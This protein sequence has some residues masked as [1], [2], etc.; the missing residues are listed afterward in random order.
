MPNTFK[1]KLAIFSARYGSQFLSAAAAAFLII[2]ANA[3]LKFI[4]VKFITEILYTIWF[5]GIWIWGLFL[6][7]YKR[8]EFKLNKEQCQELFALIKAEYEGDMAIVIRTV[9]MRQY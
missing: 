8:Y 7:H 5:A 9:S 2:F 4:E 6:S 3:H 1:T